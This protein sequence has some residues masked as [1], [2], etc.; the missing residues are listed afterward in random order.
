MSPETRKQIQWAE[1]DRA[2]A[3]SKRHEGPWNPRAMSPVTSR[4]VWAYSRDK[5]GNET[6]KHDMDGLPA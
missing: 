5:A 2:W 1:H 3:P 4:L 6:V